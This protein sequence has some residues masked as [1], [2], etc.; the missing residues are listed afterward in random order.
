MNNSPSV[1]FTEGLFFV[2]VDDSKLA[3]IPCERLQ[4]S[5]VS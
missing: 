3:R 5:L 1:C 4:E 2:L